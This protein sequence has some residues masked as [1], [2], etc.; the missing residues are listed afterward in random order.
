M[1][2]KKI[3]MILAAH[4]FRDEEYLEPRKIFEENGMKVFTCAKDVAVATGKLS[5]EVD[6]DVNL[7]D[8]KIKDYDAFIFVGGPGAYDYIDDEDINNLVTEINEDDSKVLGAICI[9]PMIL[10]SAGIL[11]GKTVTVWDE[12]KKQSPVLIKNNVH[13]SEEDVTED[14]NII[15]GNGPKASIE[16]G[17][18]IINKLEEL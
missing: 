14:E 11:D 13:Y 18:A 3:L 10:Y 7:V 8:V 15:T 12:D 1:L 6:I 2:N 17:E 5:E 4:G 16:F 9:A